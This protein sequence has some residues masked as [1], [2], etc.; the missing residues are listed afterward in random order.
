M[1]FRSSVTTHQKLGCGA[2][3][4]F[5]PQRSYC[6][7]NPD[8]SFNSSLP[9]SSTEVITVK[10]DLGD[11]ADSPWGG[12]SSDVSFSYPVLTLVLSDVPSQSSKP[13][14]E[15]D[16]MM[17]PPCSGNC[18]ANLCVSSFRL[19]SEV[20]R[21]RVFPTITD[22]NQIPDNTWTAKANPASSG[23]THNHPSR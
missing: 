14:F 23:T 7:S 4:S 18:A 20:A 1:P 12:K 19:R 5:P 11:A 15:Q 21:Y 3:A 13:P 17:S 16:G 8:D 9:R 10:M 6:F 22:L 2:R